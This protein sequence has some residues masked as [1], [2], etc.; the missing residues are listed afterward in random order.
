MSKHGKSYVESKKKVDRNR[1]Y[2]PS[3]AFEL[4]KEI[5][6]A[7]FDETV[8]LSVKLGVNP[9]HADQQVRGA[10]VL[11]NGTG[12]ELKVIVFA[13]GDKMKEAE[14]AGAN[15]VGGEDL[16]EKVQ[17]GWLDFDVAVATPDMMSVVGK[18]GRVLGPR[19]LMPNPKTGTVTFDVSRAIA[20]IKAG[21]VEYRTDK[22][23]NIHAPLGKASFSAE[24]L[25]ENFY[26]V[27]EVLI[28]ARPSAAKGQYL[29]NITISA[30]MS[31][32]IKVN[33]QK[34]AALG[35]GQ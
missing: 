18:L 17:G 14:D 12:K 34:A 13:K 20:E 15:V 22:A 6:T 16:A 31:P 25:L 21:K 3:E 2:D 29:R 8:E 35:K 28:K 30:T 32:G 1:H 7:S 23:G 27:I 24:K 4:L 10:V 5:A 33:S 11:P 26:S 19:G 9:K